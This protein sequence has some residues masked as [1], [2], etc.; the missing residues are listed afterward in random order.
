MT[1]TLKKLEKR[2]Y[3]QDKNLKSRFQKNTLE[4]LK[5]YAPEEK[6]EGEW[7]EPMKKNPAK[8]SFMVKL[9]AGLAVFA[10]VIVAAAIIYLFGGFGTVFSNQINFE[11]SGPP[12]LNGGEKA[13]WRVTIENKNDSALE[14]ADII[15][16][17]P[18]GSQP[19]G[20]SAPSSGVFTE[21]RNLGKIFS[22][23]RIDEAF[24]AFVF[25]EE[26]S[27]Q[28]ASVVLEYRV[29]GSNAIL[30]KETFLESELVKSPVSVTVNLAEYAN[31]EQEMAIEIVYSSN[32]RE[33]I[34]NLTVQAVYPDGFEFISASPEPS[35]SDNTWE[36]KSLALQDQGSIRLRGKLKGENLENKVFKSSVGVRDAKGG[37]VVYGA[38]S[39]SA[40]LRKPFLDLAVK[41]NGQKDYVASAGDQLEVAVFWKNNLPVSVK[42]AVLEVKLDSAA[43]DYSKVSVNRGFYRN[44]D[45][46]VVWNSSSDSSLAFLDP[47]QEGEASFRINVLGTL[48]SGSAKDANF[49]A[50]FD[51]HMYASQRPAG[52]EEVDIDGRFSLE[53]KIA[54]NLQLSRQGYFYSTLIPN[55]GLLPPRVGWKTTY[56][57]VWSLANSSNNLKNVKVYA[58]LPSYVSW[59]GNFLPLDENVSYDKVN[60]RVIWQMDSLAAGTGILKPAR[61]AAFQIG[62]TASPSQIGTSPVLIS[63]AIA[64]GED[65]FAGLVLRDAKNA[66]TT[67]L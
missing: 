40:V 7:K 25:G 9:I 52:F 14:D 29:Q 51:A 22:A 41:I 56:T 35:F 64:E 47:G 36:I 45:R 1:E 6:I 48:P 66:L 46:M 57:V 17:Y 11:I 18:A 67:R 58:S 19:A 63:E 13:V 38:G 23:E 60:G 15:F 34:N 24:E 50:R 27:L 61:E 16:E 54:S 26:K 10:A 33:K 30:A 4:E 65:E 43:L 49:T 39:A 32:A 62:I 5:T 53:S 12:S 8:M 44:G 2:L 59:E 31:I 42:N 3:G 55:F 20:Q 37:L 21:R 28:R